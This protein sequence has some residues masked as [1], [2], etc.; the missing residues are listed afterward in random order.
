MQLVEVQ[1][2]NSRKEFLRFPLRLYG[3]SPAYIRPLDKDVELVF[4]EAKNRAFRHGKCTRWLLLDDDQKTIGRVAAFVNEKTANKGNDQPTG[5]IGFFDCIDS[6]EAA[7]KLFDTAKSWLKDQGMEAMD[8]PINFGERDKWWGL[9]IDGF[10]REPNYCCNFNPPYYQAFFENYGFQIYF[11]QLTFGINVLDPFSEKL[12]EKIRIG[13]QVPDISFDH[14]RKNNLNKYIEDFRTIYNKAWAGHGVPQ[15]S[16]LQAKSLMK[17]VQPILDEKII[18]FAYHK[19]YPI[20]VYMNIPEIN[21]IFKHVNGKLDLIGKLKFLWHHHV[22]KS[23]RKMLGVVF[24]IVPEFQGKGIDGALI[25]ATGD[26]VQ[27]KY[28]RYLKLEM[29]WI[30]DFNPKMIRV[31]EQLDGKVVKTHATYRKLFDETKPFKRM[32][33]LG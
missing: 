5:G 31:A 18:W 30:G 25:Q 9:L 10:D 13:Q 22:I 27:V 19:D 12:L 15:L 6:E 21:Q 14:I 2:N 33:I 17:Q 29:N 1:D 3:D 24:G 4:D 26:M 8:G 28:Q 16:S 20:G 32:P 11:K 7:F 23:N